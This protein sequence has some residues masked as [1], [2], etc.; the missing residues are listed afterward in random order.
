MLR[1]IVETSYFQATTQATHPTDSIAP[2]IAYAI[3]C[4]QEAH[5]IQRQLHVLTH[6]MF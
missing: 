6:V 4:N 5:W 3:T 1:C 2:P